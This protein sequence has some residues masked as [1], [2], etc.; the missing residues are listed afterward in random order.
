MAR[1]ARKPAATILSVMLL[2]FAHGESR[3]DDSDADGI[4]DCCDN[5]AAIANSNQSDVDGDGAGDVCDCAPTDPTIFPNAPETNDGIDNQCPGDL[6]FG[7]VDELSGTIGFFDPTNKHVLSWPA[8]PGAT[9][10]VLGR[11]FSGPDS[12]PG[13]FCGFSSFT[14]TSVVTTTPGLGFIQF[15]IAGAWNPHRGSLGRTSDGAE[16]HTVICN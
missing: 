4:D 14:T 9:N 10:Y 7:S 8:Q 16:R 13:V 15:Y 12:N 3:A 1:R 6:D 2:A 5:C 11:S